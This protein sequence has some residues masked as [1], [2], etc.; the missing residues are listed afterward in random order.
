MPKFALILAASGLL[1]AAAC[2]G[3]L[4]SDMKTE[5][6]AAA[7]LGSGWQV[8]GGGYDNVKYSPLA[9]I[10]TKNV[11]L[12]EEVWRYDTGDA[13]AG[14]EMQANPIVIGRIL[15]AVSP[16]QRLIALDAAKGNLIWAFDP[17]E[18]KAEERLSRHRGVAYWSD[19]AQG[20][21]FYAVGPWLHAVDAATGRKVDGFGDGG[22]V[23]LRDGLG[24]DPRL[25]SVSATSP[26]VVY[27][28]LLIIGSS[29]AEDLPAAPGDIRAYDV[30]TGAL[31]WSFRTIPA[32]GEPGS[33]TWPERA[34]ETSGGANSWAGL[35][36]DVE[37]G[38]VFAPTGSAAFDFWG[39]DRPGD[40]LFANSLLALDAATGE[41]VWHFQ[42]VRHDIWDRDLPTP[43]SLIRIERGGKSIDAVAQITKSGHLYLF[44][45]ETGRALFPIEDVAVPRSDVPGEVTA[46]TQPHP[47]APP[48][49]ARQ[50]FDASQVTSR[51]GEAR[52]AVLERLSGLRFGRA[53]EPPSLQGT[54]IFPGLDG[55]GEWGGAAFDRDTGLLYVNSNEMPWI[56]RLL[57]RIRPAGDAVD[58]R[59][60][61][62]ANCASC[63]GADLAGQ[64]DFPPLRDIS[65]RL[66]RAQV[67]RTI[68][69][70]SAR[71]PAFAT[72]GPEAISALA[73]YLLTG[74]ARAVAGGRSVA[75]DLPFRLE[76]YDR[77]LDPDG[78][79]AVSPPWG[80][81]TA[82]DINRGEIRWQIPFGEFPELVAKGMR[83]TGSENY[84]GPVV[85]AGGLLFIGATTVDRKFR[86]FDKANGRLLWETVL[87]ASA[88][89]TPAVYQVDGRQF[90]VIAAG[91]GKTGQPSG[92]SYVAFALPRAGTR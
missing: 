5:P 1:F 88:T 17:H 90:V 46:P 75:N 40:N 21:I 45:R 19:G 66:S 67:E 57:P 9:E 28:D 60:L 11:H 13:F 24:R 82:I 84:G 63:H 56:L 4:A 39:G 49:F 41:R 10:T 23:D 59:S 65:A 33:E 37:R 20:R 22:R 68:G 27:K 76:G 50:R 16:R 47:L 74:E 18:G 80:Q 79:P 42:T 6:A 14:S 52:R 73:H 43:P 36:L 30:R 55:G 69:Q 86:A 62:L 3:R 85:T 12:L 77:F 91:G 32:P 64:A 15:Y 29:L 87:P 51:T 44:E 34:R 25:I 26:G 83:N 54:V 35:S 7:P 8:A 58:G 31:R 72:L 48:P 38:L 2:G 92:G 71:M 53:F 89:A 78:Y 61:Y 81:L 70:G